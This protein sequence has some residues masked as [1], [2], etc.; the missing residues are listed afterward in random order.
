MSDEAFVERHFALGDQKVVA[1]FHTPA[2]APGGEYQCRWQIV[3]PDRESKF[4]ACGIDGV[5]ALMLAMRAVHSELVESEE[6]RSGL[7]TYL[8]QQDLDLPPAWGNGALYDAGPR[9]E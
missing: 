3:W 2:L 5:Q 6:Y 7:L 1:R 4:R 9:P 8:D